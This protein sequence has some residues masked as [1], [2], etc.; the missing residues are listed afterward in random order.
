MAL[1]DR[2][3]LRCGCGR[4][5]CIETWCA[6]AG[7]TRR[8][9]EV[10]PQAR[11]ADG[12]PTPR[13]AA[14]VFALANAGDPDAV[15]L[16]GRARHALATGIAVILASVAPGAVTVG[17][18]IG[19]SQPAFVRSAFVEATRMVHRSAGTAVQLRKPQLGDA[20]VLVGAAVLGRRAAS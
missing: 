7:L 17:G 11:S 9:R 5:N 19:L 16:V 20:S 10:W 6:G 14:A 18:S 13:D 8:A 1:G 15:A 4:R 12:I 3:G 2:E